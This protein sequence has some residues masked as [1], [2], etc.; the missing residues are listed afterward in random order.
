MAEVPQGLTAPGSIQSIRP[1]EVTQG[2]SDSTISKST[3][4]P[5]NLDNTLAVDLAAAQQTD[6]NKKF[7]DLMKIRVSEALGAK[8]EVIVFYNTE[9]TINKALSAQPNT[10]N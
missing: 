8:G 10:S 2:I 4:I 6:P 9:D 7:S 3:K 1:V 5:D